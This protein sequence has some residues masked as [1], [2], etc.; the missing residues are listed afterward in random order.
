MDQI[1]VG[2][3][4]VEPLRPLFDADLHLFGRCRLERRRAVSN[5][6]NRRTRLFFFV[7]I[8]KIKLKNKIELK[9]KNFNLKKI[10]FFE[11]FDGRKKSLKKN[12]NN[13]KNFVKLKKKKNF[14]KNEIEEKN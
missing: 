4:F 8:Q 12:L 2:R 1:D 14:Q 13:K 3:H 5:T 9:K 6:V 11:N 7:L 10:F